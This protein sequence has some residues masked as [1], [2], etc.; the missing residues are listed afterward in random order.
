MAHRRH[1][2]MVV[3]ARRSA[4]IAIAGDPNRLIADRIARV[5]LLHVVRLEPLS[6]LGHE[7]AA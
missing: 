3:L 2:E 4:S 5:P 6:A 1:P 7:G